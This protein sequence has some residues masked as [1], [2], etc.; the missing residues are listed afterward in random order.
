MKKSKWVIDVIAF[1]TL[2]LVFLP[3]LTGFALHEWI[4]LAITGVLLVHFLQH[5]NW[6]ISTTQRLGKL[7]GKILSWYLLDAGLAIGFITITGT[8]LV[9][10]SL[11]ML[12]L[13]NYAAWSYIHVLSSYLTAFL[14]FV[15]LVLHWAGIYKMLQKTFGLKKDS[16][17]PSSLTIDQKKRRDFLR[18][19]G[20]TAIAGVVAITEFADWQKSI[21]VNTNSNDAQIEEDPVKAL[22]EVVPTSVP[23][24]V[25]T[26]QTEEN[27]EFVSVDD[28]GSEPTQVLTLA[29]T[30]VPTATAEI[31]NTGVVKCRKGCSYPGKCGRYTDTANNN[32]LCD[33]GEPIW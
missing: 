20:V 26:Q 25:P 15:K 6:T 11:L 3:G 16:A 32:D 4:G 14:L 9:I 12:P 7:K 22:V 27:L 19:A 21:V 24:L 30:S 23:T 17:V 5:W 2:L 13:E 33:L 8:G 29:P 18:G 31:Q 10:S 28:E 1:L